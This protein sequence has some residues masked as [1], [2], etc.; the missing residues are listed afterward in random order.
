MKDWYLGFKTLFPVE[1]LTRHDVSIY[2][3][4]TVICNT[5]KMYLKWQF[6]K[7]YKDESNR[8]RVFSLFLAI[9]KKIISGDTLCWILSVC[10]EISGNST[11]FNL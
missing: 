10:P 7:K 6:K 11:A 8:L 2:S 3:A 9:E 1:F 5:R 4:T